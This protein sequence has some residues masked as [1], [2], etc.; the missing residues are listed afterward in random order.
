VRGW[1]NPPQ[2]ELNHQALTAHRAGFQLAVHAIEENTVEAAV[3]ALEHSLGQLP[4]D[5]HRHRI[6]HCS[7]CPPHLLQRLQATA[8]VVVTQPA[9]IYYSG[10]R[11]LTTVPTSQLPGLYR[12]RSFLTSNLRPA[13]G[14]DAPVVPPNPL[15]GIYASLTRR[16]E[17]GQ[18]LS[19]KEAIT[20]EQALSMHTAAAAYA[21]FEDAVKG[22]IQRGKLAD[23][24]LLS[25]DPTTIEPEELKEIRVEKT[26]VA[27]EVVWAR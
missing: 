25:A 27:G 26:I 20:A 5:D 11:Y 10:E 6:E 18:P 4:R 14:S 21:S 22:T 12:I 3:T 13:A 19:P 15:I 24:V 16:A 23:L 2:E 9:F 17:T 1:L 8:A 7:V